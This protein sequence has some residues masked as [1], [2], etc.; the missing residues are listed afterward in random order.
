VVAVDIS[1]ISG[2]PVHWVFSS[3]NTRKIQEIQNAISRLYQAVLCKYSLPKPDGVE[4]ERKIDSARVSSVDLY[5][6]DSMLQAKFSERG[7]PQLSLRDALNIGVYNIF[8]LV[9]GT[10][11]P[12]EKSRS[13]SL[14][15][16]FASMKD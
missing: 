15:N 11:P 7:S 3:I 10:L 4:F 2:R 9:F 8:N 5:D 1:R 14:T 12:L 16:F 6:I 13:Q